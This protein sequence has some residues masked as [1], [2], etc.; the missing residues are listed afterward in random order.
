MAG[1]GRVLGVTSSTL[2]NYAGEVDESCGGD[3]M[4]VVLV[5]TWEW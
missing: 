3:E 5:R 2:R 1:D 4:G